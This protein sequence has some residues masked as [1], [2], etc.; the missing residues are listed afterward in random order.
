MTYF[1]PDKDDQI[2]ADLIQSVSH[3]EYWKASEDHVLELALEEIRR[4][5]HVFRMLDLGCG[6]G[7]M[8]SVFAPLSDSLLALEP[9]SERCRG[10]EESAAL[11]PEQKISVLNADISILKEEM[12]DV[13]LSSHVLQ[14]IQPALC[15]SMVTEISRHLKQGGL[16][17]LTTTHTGK[18]EDI[19]TIE[20]M[21]NGKRQTKNTELAEFL[22]AFNQKGIL[23]VRLF[24]E[25]T[26]IS[27]FRR[28]HFELLCRRRFHYDG[29]ES[30]EYDDLANE[31][32]YG[33]AGCR[34]E[35]VLP[36]A[37]RY[38]ARARDAFYL[39]RRND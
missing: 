34:A 21:V 22:S 24:A 1:Y 35:A 28:N 27:L 11:L 39:F 14:H 6:M 8:F 32:I 16:V 37:V 13:I 30:I 25:N 23:P 5:P 31:E 20:T 9:D 33:S 10:A 17:I 4:L 29:A 7:R 38:T 3:N 26:I 19:Y 12:F 36:E 2:T 15:E 18:K